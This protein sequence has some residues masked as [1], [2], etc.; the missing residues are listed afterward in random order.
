MIFFKINSIETNLKRVI[1]KS[2][3]EVIAA[4]E[5]EIFEA[6]GLS[7]IEPEERNI[8]IFRCCSSIAFEVAW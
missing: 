3:R 2:S 1:E 4:T 6:L 5:K 7:Y 8:E